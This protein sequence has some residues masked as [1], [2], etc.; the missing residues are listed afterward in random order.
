MKS[1]RYFECVLAFAWLITALFALL[2]PI[3]AVAFLALL[4]PVWFFF[5]SVLICAAAP[6]NAGP[7][8]PRFGF[9][10]VFSPRPPPIR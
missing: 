3:T 5:A 2:N 6:A 1:R 8:N 10:P 7:V 4:V 9:V